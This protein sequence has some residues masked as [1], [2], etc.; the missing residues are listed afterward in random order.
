MKNFD[1]LNPLI[2]VNVDQLVD[3]CSTQP[4]PGNSVWAPNH[5]IWDCFLPGKISPKE[6]WKDTRMLRKAVENM[7]WII[8]KGLAENKYADFNEKHI[9]QIN[10]C[11][12]ENGKIISSNHRLLELILTRFTVAKIA[13]KVTALNKNTMYKIMEESHIDFSRGVY[14]PMAG[15]G[16][17]IEAAK[18]WFKKHSVP[19]KNDS[20]DYLIEAYDINPNFCNWYGWGERNMLAEHIKTDK[21]VIVCPP[22]GDKY[23]H[24]KGTPDDMSDISFLEWYFLIH[25]FINAP[26]YMII[27]PELKGKDKQKCGLFYKTT[28]IQLW[29]DDMYN[30]ALQKERKN[31]DRK[32]PGTIEDRKTK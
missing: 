19:M 15:F 17:I 1:K 29:T 18:M 23:E 27:G 16:G 12:V 32:I 26:N 24:W 30:E 7:F 3:F 13:P 28:G 10:S 21:S 14:A 20:Y 5:P 31:Y 22:F 6:A 9:K 8:N 2:K 25:D 11:K 4:F